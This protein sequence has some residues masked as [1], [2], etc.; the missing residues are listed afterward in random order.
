MRRVLLTGLLGSLLVALGG[1]VIGRTPPGDWVSRLDPLADV[2]A[3]PPGAGAGYSCAF[4]GLGLLTW[5]WVTLGTLVRGRPDGVTRVRTAVGLWALPLL[6][7]PPLFS[8]D[9]WSYV[10]DGLLTGHHLS[11][12]VVPPS[13]LTGP[14]LQAVSSRWLHAVAPYGPLPM[15]WGG[16]AA[17]LSGNLWLILY[18]YRALAVVGLGLLMYAVP[19][20]AALAGRDPATASWLAVGSPLVLAHGVA[21]LHLDLLMVGLMAL[22]LL[23]AATRGWLPASVVAGA[24]MAVKLPA[25]FVVVGVVLLSLADGSLV[26]RIRHTLA[27]GAVATATMVALGLSGGVGIGFVGALHVHWTHPSWLSATRYVGLVAQWLAGR[28]AMPVVAVGGVLLLGIVSVVVVL[29]TPLRDPVASGTAAAVVLGLTTVVAPV[30]HYWYFLWCLPVLACTRLDRVST[31]AVAGL[32]LVLGVVAPVDPSRP[33]VPF[34]PYFVRGA[35]AAALVVAALP[36]TALDRLVPPGWWRRGRY[37]ARVHEVE[38][39]SGQ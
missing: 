5:A 16:A 23:L 4:A 32:I 21:G 35:I 12:Y 9:G 39:R 22:A 8:G 2:R 11:P 20:F 1:F 13:A 17:H 27:V 38:D 36:P 18:A 26:G 37:D 10:A 33:P 31:R 30:V 6:P 7:T 29:R 25:L 28:P 15:L 14:I 19:R 3:W 34:A 24:A